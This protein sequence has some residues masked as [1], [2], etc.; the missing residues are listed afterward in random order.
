MCLI[1]DE[2]VIFL[3]PCRN[4]PQREKIGLRGF[5]PGLTQVGPYS[6]RR[7]LEAIIFGFK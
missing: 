4:D 6:H 2:V 5:Q 7:R 3:L 1:M